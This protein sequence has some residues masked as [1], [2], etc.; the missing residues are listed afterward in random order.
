MAK[1]KLATPQPEAPLPEALETAVQSPLEALTLSY[2]NKLLGDQA[3]ALCE[4][5][6]ALDLAHRQINALQKQ[7]IDL[8]AKLAAGEKAPTLPRKG[9][10]PPKV[11]GAAHASH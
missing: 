8:A 6:A 1:R 11:N 4:A 10:R 9:A 7:V 3:G 5:R 2:K